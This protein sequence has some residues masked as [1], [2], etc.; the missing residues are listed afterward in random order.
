MSDAAEPTEQPVPVEEATARSPS[1]QPTEEV[2][3]PPLA[4]PSPTRPPAVSSPPQR[5]ESPSARREPS[6]RPTSHSLPPVPA[7]PASPP[8]NGNGLQDPAYPPAEQPYDAAQ[9]YQNGGYDY[10]Q[11]YAQPPASASGSGTDYTN[12]DVTP[13]PMGAAKRGGHAADSMG[14]QRGVL[15]PQK[16]YIGGL[17]E[18]TRVED[19]QDCFSQLGNVL[20]IE[21]KAG[22]G[23]VVRSASPLAS[24]IR[25]GQMHRNLI[26]SNRRKKR[27][28]STTVVTSSAPRSESSSRTTDRRRNR[29][30]EARLE[31]ASSAGVRDIGREIARHR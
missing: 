12:N 29:T 13:Q 17:P 25:D 6:P 24:G 14:Q 30:S 21:L 5:S 8:A 27:S 10:S 9:Y 31:R 2:E 20:S 1:P 18:H 26:A 16:I 28:T 11:Y 4:E 3:A 22:F 7:R 23:F 15:N 19:L